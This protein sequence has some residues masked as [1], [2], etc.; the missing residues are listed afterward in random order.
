MNILKYS[1]PGRIYFGIDSIKE[2]ASLIRSKGKRVFFITDP[3]LRG[4]PRFRSLLFQLQEN[5]L[6]TVV[7]D[8]LPALIALDGLNEATKLAKAG[9]VDIIAA[10]G[11]TSATLA[12][13]A[14]ALAVE[15][16]TAKSII[17][18]EGSEDP[19][20]VYS[21]TTAIRNYSVYQPHGYIIN[22]KNMRP[23]FFDLRSVPV[24]YAFFDSSFTD[25]LSVKTQ[26][27]IALDIIL[28]SIEG[29]LEP[30]N[31]FILKT[32]YSES[33]VYAFAALD[34]YTKNRHE[35]GKEN[36]WKAGILL[37]MTTDSGKR[38]IG[39]ALSEAFRLSHQVPRSWT[40]AVLLPHL[41]DE[42]LGTDPDLYRRIVHSIDEDQF[43]LTTSEAALYLGSLVRRRIAQLELPSRLSDLGIT[44]I[45]LREGAELAIALTA[46]GKIF[47]S[48]WGIK[49]T[50][51]LAERAL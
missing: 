39:S 27:T 48:K 46:P 13:K 35:Q 24:E 22:K 2:M 32:L 38:G 41:L 44:S 23:M 43:H 49:E 42:N 12:A 18:S 47:K 11:G 5:D 8:N 28:A 25:A 20:P 37:T 33:L 26:S 19:L 50:I 1:L 14:V 51:A 17:N 36:Q 7:Y 3:E 6:N 45:Q 40:S 4:S 9:Q 15:S 30:E 29:L 16:G 31:S 21:F 10:Y 34:E